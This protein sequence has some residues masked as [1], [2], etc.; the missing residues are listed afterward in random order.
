MRAASFPAASSSP[1]AQH[2]HAA[3]GALQQMLPVVLHQLNAGFT[4]TS[5]ET[6]CRWWLLAFDPPVAGAA[7]PQ[8]FI[9]V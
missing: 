4:I 8:Q 9:S 3:Q 6:V 7:S 1:S 2:Q 5:K